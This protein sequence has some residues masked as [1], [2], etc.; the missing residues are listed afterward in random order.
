MIR[1]TS[2]RATGRGFA[3][4]DL[5]HLARVDQGNDARGRI[6]DSEQTALPLRDD[7]ELNRGLVEA[8]QKLLE[9]SQ[10]R[11]L[12]LADGLTRRLDLE[13]SGAHLLARFFLRLTRRGAWA[14]AGLG[15]GVGSLGLPPFPESSFGGVRELRFSGCTGFG[16]SLRVTRP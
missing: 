4:V 5:D 6:A 1:S 10:C 15:F 2:S 13:R 14:S 7:L 9:L 11:P 12:R 8:G 16:R 3:L